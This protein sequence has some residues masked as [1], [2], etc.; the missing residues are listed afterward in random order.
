MKIGI[1][2]D[3]YR[4]YNSGVVKSIESF[5]NQFTAMGHQVFVFGPHYPNCEKEERVYRFISI[6]APTQPDFTIAIPIS[7]NLRRDI[8]ELGIDIIHAQSPFMLGRLGAKFARIYNI[9]LVFTYHTLYDQYV[10][11]LPIMKDLSK[12]LMQKVGTDFCNHCDL[13]I[14]PTGIVEKHLRESGVETPVVN[15]PTGI[16]IDEFENMDRRW[17]REHYGYQEKETIL[18]HVGRMGKEKNIPFLL[19]AYD[20]VRKEEPDARL[21]IVGGGSEEGHLQKLAREMGISDGVRFTG[22]LPRRQV[23][24]AYAGADLFIF[25]SLTE[26]QG[27]VLCEAKAAGLPL[28]AIRAFGAAE[29]VENREDGF[30]T[31]PSLEE[32]TERVLQ[33]LRD[34]GL[35]GQMGQKARDNAE[36]MS[37]YNQARKLLDHYEGLLHSHKKV[38]A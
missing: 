22:M 27:L 37:S 17:L 19:E 6:P 25:A 31:G 4:P 24:D 5:S 16:E 35:R 14:A 7:A 34:R 13:V 26:T 32:F 1:F 9:P 23:I 15:I 38:F 33:L 21:V 12:K 36:K 28:V 3:S 10:H 18:L 11:Y 29:M 30:L 20:R 2:T 8:K